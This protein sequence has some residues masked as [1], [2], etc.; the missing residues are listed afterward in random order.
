MRYLK[1]A[2]VVAILLACAAPAAF[3]QVDRATLTGVVRDPSNAVVPG[4]SVKV[5]NLATGVEQTSTTSTDGAYF[6]VNLLPGQ[7]AIEASAAGFQSSAQTVQLE[8]GQRARLDVS[9]AVGGVGETVRVEG[10]TPLLDT[11]SAVLGSVVSRQEVAN[12]PLAIRNWDDLLFTVPG[13]Q[14]DRYTEQTGTT[15]AGRTGGVSIHGNRSLQNNF[16]LDGVDNN[17]ISTNVQ[18]LS[19]QV[20]RPS[21]DAIDE[22][23]VVTSPFTAEYGRAPGGAIV[24]TTKSGTNRVS[25]TAYDYY[26]NEN[27]DS[28]SFFAKRQNLE[29]PANDQNQFGLNIG[30]PIVRNRAFFFGDFEATR[31]TQ[32]VLRTGRVAT[33]DERNGIFTS[34]IRDPLT[35]LPFENNRIP[36]DRIDPVARN[37]MNLVPLPNASGTNNF[38]RQPNVEDDGERYLLKTDLKVSNSDNVFMRFIYTDRTRFV[39]GWFGGIIDGTSTSAWG[40]NYLKSYSTVGGWT[41]V[42]GPTMVNELRVSWARGV[43]DGQQDPFG[44]DGLAQIGFRGVPANDAVL[45]GI[46]GVDITGHIRLGSPNFM[47]KYQH[48]DQVQYLD[49]VSWLKGRHQ[50]K[51]GTDIMMPMRNEYIDVPSTRGNLQFS[52]QYSGNAVADFMLGWARTAELSNVHIANQRR[53]ST[54][55]FVQDDWRPSD[56]L[57]INLGLRY[58]YMTPSYDANNQMANFDPASGSLVFAADGDIETR[59]LIKPDRNNIG[60][61]IGFVYQ[62]TPQTV[63]RGGYGLF[64]N[65]LDRIGS[66]DQL[67]LNPP[68]LRNINQTTTSTT[69]AVLLMRDGFPSNYL[70]PANVVLSRL[71]IRA[72]NPDGTNAES[73]QVAIGVERQ[74][75]RD[76]VVSADFVGNSGSHISVL[77][78]LNQ[79]ANGNGARPYPNFSHIQWRDPI[80]ESAYKGIDFSAEKRMSKGYS[81][82]VAYTWS[83]S[84]DQAPEHLA[85]TSGRPQDTNNIAAWEGPSDFDVRHRL[86]ANFIAESPVGREVDL[87]A[88]GNAVLGG[89]T[90]SG[91]YTARSGRPFTVTQGSLEGATWL[92]NLAGDPEGQK[93]V[94][95]WFNVAA[96]QRVPAGTF[97]NAGRNIVRGP[98]YVTFDLSLQRRITL[99]GRL[100]ATL[101][102]DV[103]NLFDRANFGTPNSDITGSTVGTISSL[104]GDPRVMQLA[105][106]LHF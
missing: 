45:G 17:S 86:V 64:V 98:G 85:A 93:T 28:R 90:I 101:R 47:P 1:P 72:A 67:S 65:P 33:A 29:K 32:G 27:F 55:F 51:F 81:Y 89:W 49:T 56:R 96:F 41:K 100:A 78:N 44:Q 42:I 16:V 76:F 88:A 62:F 61:R 71:L 34:V 82:R 57:T 35:G 73:Q 92:P 7:Y 46:M 79:P 105:I 87:G 39:P 11:Q 54:A 103:F 36:A 20:S 21:I 66:E 9:L 91:I 97:G 104:A 50:I 10:I 5:I 106:R 60:P 70:D 12:L 74:L 75:G 52:G 24:V 8:V 3:A 43:S 68:G 99:T 23:R 19:T 25:G 80:G 30:G 59:A 31:I 53:Y 14:G 77:R 58:D 69:T 4:A 94:D 6:V 22:F 95:G 63:L 102:W 83:D 84:R 13:V 48:T 26:R 15:N 18:E 37:I 40:R 38:I 2:F